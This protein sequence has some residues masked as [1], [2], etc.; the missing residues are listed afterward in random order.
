MPKSPRFRPIPVRGNSARL[1]EVLAFPLVQLLDVTGPLQ[2]FA[3]ANDHVAQAGGTPPYVLRVVA[4]GGQG[5]MATAGL[6]IAT[7]PLPRTGT[8][9]DTLIVPGGPGVDAAAADTALV[10][11]LRQRANKARRVAS[12]CTGAFLLGATGMLDGRRAVTHWS[13]CVELARRFPAAQVEPDPIFVHDGPVWTSAG[14]TAGIDLALALVEEDLGR[15]VALAV[16]RYLVVFLKRPGGQAQFSEAL[17]MQSAEDEF[18]ALHQW[19][20]KHLSDDL[21]LAMLADQ[22]GMSERSFSRHYAGATGVT[23]ARAIERLRVEAARR[24]LSES[25][26][27]VKRISQRCGFGSEETMRRSFLRVL[28]ATPNDYRARFSS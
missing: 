15:T 2:V 6:G 7:S 24:L 20:N 5:V 22:A 14:V 21:S 17:S 16:A 26:L 27:P 10:D 3:S 13:F 28:S 23:P 11:W 25:R 1:V 19:I 12:V 4:R 18:G 9:P 8:P